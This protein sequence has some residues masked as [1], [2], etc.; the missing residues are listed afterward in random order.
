ML[1]RRQEMEPNSNLVTVK[2]KKNAMKQVTQPMKHVTQ[3]LAAVINS[4][5]W[6]DKSEAATLDQLWIW[7][8]FQKEKKLY[9]C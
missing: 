1:E 7:L 9:L 8:L 3:P 2:V 4:D 5:Q 6:N